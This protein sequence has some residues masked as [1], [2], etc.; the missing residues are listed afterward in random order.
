MSAKAS[1]LEFLTGI[2]PILEQ[3]RQDPRSIRLIRIGRRDGAGDRVL[4]AAKAA[5][6]PV[7]REDPQALRRRA[8]GVLDQGIVA[9]IAPFRYAELEDLLEARVDCLVALDQ[10]TDPRNLGAIIRSAEAAGAGGVIV[11]K[12][13][14]AGVTAV[15]ARA[16]AGATAVVPVARVTNLT[17]ALEASKRAGYWI[18]GLDAEAPVSLFGFDFPEAS[19]I[20]IGAEGRGLRPLVRSSCDHRLAIPMLGRVS[21][22]NASVAAAIALFERVRQRQSVDS[23]KRR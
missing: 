8:G 18:V 5:G 7:V 2:N 13:R 3:L 23:L 12:D 15:V 6:V 10:I 11:P 20:V 9:E 17:R 16:A 1:N 4:E 14:A 21:S 19:V 22:L